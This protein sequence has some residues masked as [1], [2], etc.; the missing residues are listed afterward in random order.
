MKAKDDVNS[1][2]KNL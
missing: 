2:V 1:Y